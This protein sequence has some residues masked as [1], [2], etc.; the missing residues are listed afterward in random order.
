MRY[1][2]QLWADLNTGMLL[3]AKTFNEKNEMLEQF[4]FH[5]GEDRRPHQPR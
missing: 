5:P 4:K 1:G 3:R 2:H